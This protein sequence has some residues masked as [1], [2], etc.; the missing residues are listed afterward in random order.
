MKFEVDE[1]VIKAT[2]RCEKDFACL[3]CEEKVYC[4]VE[5]CLMHRVHFVKCLHDKP[6]AY[7]VRVDRSPVCT[8]PVRKEIFRRY[9]K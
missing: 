4:P 8:C 1:A 6:C 7:K 3:E 9:G 5:A 2:T